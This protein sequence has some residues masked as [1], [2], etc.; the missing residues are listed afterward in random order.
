[1]ESIQNNSWF[2]PVKE[3][4]LDVFHHFFWPQAGGLSVDSSGNL[5]ITNTGGSSAGDGGMGSGS[6]D[7]TEKGN[8]QKPGE[9]SG[10]ATSNED[11]E[12]VTF[13]PLKKN[14][15]EAEKERSKE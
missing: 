12:D 1:M 7:D 5:V 2:N 9:K 8:L 13:D 6:D 3:K 11:D 10:S 15:R 14:A 4:K